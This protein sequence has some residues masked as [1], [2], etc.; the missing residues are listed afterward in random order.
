MTEPRKNTNPG[1][2]NGALSE[3]E[4]PKTP[5]MSGKPMV[6]DNVLTVS[7]APFIAPFSEAGTWEG[8]EESK[9]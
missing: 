7:A 8:V 2:L 1:S 4:Y 9:G 3:I 5:V 6:E